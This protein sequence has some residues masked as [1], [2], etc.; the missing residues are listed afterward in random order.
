M[1]TKKELSIICLG[2]SMKFGPELEFDGL[3]NS[4][5][6]PLLLFIIIIIYSA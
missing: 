2:G 6:T 3:N 4:A 5:M 1:L